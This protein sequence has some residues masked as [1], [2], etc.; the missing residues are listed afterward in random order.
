VPVDGSLAV[1]EHVCWFS[2]GFIHVELTP[3]PC[4]LRST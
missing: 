1:L 2:A 3:A 4:F